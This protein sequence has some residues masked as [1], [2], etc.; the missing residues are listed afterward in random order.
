MVHLDT[1]SDALLH[2]LQENIEKIIPYQVALQSNLPT[3]T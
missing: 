1:F 2:I 3:K